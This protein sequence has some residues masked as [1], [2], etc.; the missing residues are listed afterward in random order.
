ME[1]ANRDAT[2]SDQNELA[3]N[4]TAENATQ[5]LRLEEHQAR[6]DA[7]GTC[8]LTSDPTLCA[9][10]RLKYRHIISVMTALQSYESLL[11]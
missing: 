7:P 4:A 9:R 8:A 1:H 10:Q 11:R 2:D 3:H 6:H 5:P